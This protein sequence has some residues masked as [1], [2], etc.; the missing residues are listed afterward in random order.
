MDTKH[1]EE[2]E[3]TPASERD[4]EGHWISP[5]VGRDLAHDRSREIERQL[6]EA[7]QAKEAKRAKETNG[8]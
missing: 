7:Q 2:H 6:R 5:T 4:T 8:R 3:P 1:T